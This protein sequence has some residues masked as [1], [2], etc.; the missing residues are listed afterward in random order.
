MAGHVIFWNSLPRILLLFVLCLLRLPRTLA[1][2]A[3]IKFTDCFTGNTSIKLDV[4]TVYAQVLLVN[5]QRKLNFTVIGTT[6]QEIIEASDSLD[7]VASTCR[8]R[9]C[10]NA[11]L[12]LV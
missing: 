11:V 1:Q 8:Q 10:V 9:Y 4:S 3:A 6:P 7:P 12:T 5:E 2:P